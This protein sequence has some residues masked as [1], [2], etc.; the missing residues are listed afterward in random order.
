LNLPR[1]FSP[2]DRAHPAHRLHRPAIPALH[3]SKAEVGTVLTERG[4]NKHLSE[5]RQATR[6]LIALG[7]AGVGGGD[8]G[9]RIHL[10]RAHC[11][12]GV[13]VRCDH[14]DAAALPAQALDLACQ[15]RSPFRWSAQA[16]ELACF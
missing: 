13:G 7:E 9:R 6:F 3:P 2:G 15:V 11:G 12:S 14:L 1:S 5:E 16:F 8:A 10:I 4:Y